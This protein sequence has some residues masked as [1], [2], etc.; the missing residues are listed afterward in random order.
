MITFR[1]ALTADEFH[2]E[3]EPAGK[4][5][6]WRRN[7]ATQTWKTRPAHFRIPVKYGLRSY[8]QIYDHD[9]GRF[10]VA[11]ECPSRSF[12]VTCVSV[13]CAVD[14]STGKPYEDAVNHGRP[15]SS[16]EAAQAYVRESMRD[17]T[18]YWRVYLYDATGTRA[19]RGTRS[20]VG[21]GTANGKRWIFE[22]VTTPA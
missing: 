2:E 15:F 1:Q 16:I 20:D 3:H 4:I 8:G 18:V 21:G 11:S 13:R 10:H 12:T 17:L 9:A 6:T 22:P 5:Y 14:P 7:G 19:M